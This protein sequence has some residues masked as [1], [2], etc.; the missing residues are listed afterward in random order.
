M[1]ACLAAKPS[2]FRK[3][4]VGRPEAL[5]TSYKRPGILERTPDGIADPEM[6]GR[7]LRGQ[8]ASTG[9]R[10]RTGDRQHTIIPI[11]RIAYSG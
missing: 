9:A 10:A 11:S 4:G 8:I 6:N 3:Q 2:R 7:R 1:A 5:G